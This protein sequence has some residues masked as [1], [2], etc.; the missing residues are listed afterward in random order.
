MLDS[1]PDVLVEIAAEVQ[2]LRTFTRED[3]PRITPFRAA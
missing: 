2:D 1:I 3:V